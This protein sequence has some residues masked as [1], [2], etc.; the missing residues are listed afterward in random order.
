MK[1]LSDF[2]IIEL[3]NLRPEF[4]AEKMQQYVAETNGCWRW[5]GNFT[6]TAKGPEPYGRLSIRHEK[7]TRKLR[8]HRVSYALHHGVDP[9]DLQVCHKCDNTL[10]IN[11]SHLFLGTAFDNMQDMVKKCR[12]ARQDGQHNHNSKLTKDS[13]KEIIR[14]I[15][16]GRTNKAIAE[17]FDVSHSAVSLIRRGKQWRDAAEEVGYEPKAK[18]TRRTPAKQESAA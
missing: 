8:A 17:D 10:C 9:G 5:T 13:A 1:R 6:Y 2:S 15:L 16:L 3:I 4:Y 14:Q 7:S 11:P 12:F 18:F